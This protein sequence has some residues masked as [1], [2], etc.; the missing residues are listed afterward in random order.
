MQNFI[1]KLEIILLISII[2]ILGYLAVNSNVKY[3]MAEYKEVKV[4]ILEKHNSSIKLL[5]GDRKIL[6]LF[7]K[8]IDLMG[9]T[10]LLKENKE[11]LFLGETDLLLKDGKSF[12]RFNY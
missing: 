4:K 11:T 3:N 5:V 9:F 7:S 2:G 12:E 10:S 8:H 6:I 1:K